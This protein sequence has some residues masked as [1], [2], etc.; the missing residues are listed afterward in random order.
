MIL[1][2]AFGLTAY[3]GVLG[4]LAQ[5]FSPFLA[6]LVRIRRPRRLIAWATA[7]ATTWPG[8]PRP[9]VKFSSTA[10]RDLRERFR[11]RRHGV[12]SGLYRDRS[13]LCVVRW[14]RDA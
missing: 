8:S 14:M 7:D 1:A 10:L 9:L 2:V 6:F 5:A 11:T 12:L 3:A 13:V 4:V